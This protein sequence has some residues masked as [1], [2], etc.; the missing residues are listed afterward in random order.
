MSS[1]GRRLASPDGENDETTTI[2]HVNMSSDFFWLSN[3]TLKKRIAPTT[4][5]GPVAQPFL[6]LPCEHRCVEEVKKMATN[7]QPTA[8]RLGCAIHFVCRYSHLDS[9]L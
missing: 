6:L 8:G 7:V 1:T 2:H 9:N 5:K 3:S 4:F